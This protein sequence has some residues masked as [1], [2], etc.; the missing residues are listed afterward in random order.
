MDS[1]IFRML[2]AHFTQ[3]LLPDY[4]PVLSVSALMIGF[5][6][7]VLEGFLIRLTTTI[8]TSMITIAIESGTLSAGA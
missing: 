7:T 5:V 3:R 8:S 1:S 2:C 6:N 4:F